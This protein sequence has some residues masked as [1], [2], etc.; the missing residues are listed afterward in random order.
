MSELELDDGI[1]RAVL[2]LRQAGIETFASCEGGAG[3]PYPEPTIRFHGERSE[4]FRAFAIVMEN[5]LRVLALRRTW[6]VVDGEP[7]G[8]E[9][10]LTF[11]RRIRICQKK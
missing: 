10:E 9:W 8:P 4:G 7:S 1:K 6:Q 5:G 11:N 2:L 3:H